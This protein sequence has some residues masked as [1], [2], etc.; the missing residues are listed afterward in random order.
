[1]HILIA[2]DDGYLAPGLL[3]LVNALRPLGKIT[4]IAPEQNHSGASNSLTLSRPLTVNRMAGG[5]RDNFLYVNGT[6][7]DCVH[8][9]LTGLLDSKPDL[10]VSGINQ[11][12]NMGE[13]V[14]YSGTVA[15]AIEGV[16]F[17]IPAIAFSQ[18]AKGWARLDDAAQIAR[19]IVMQQINSPVDGVLTAGEKPTLLN[20][21]I[22][23]LPYESLKS[24]RVTRL[25][26]RHH[27]QNVIMQNNP[28]G[29]PIYWIG[30][31]GDARD[32]TE[33]TDF[34]AINQGQVSITPLQ[35][36]LSHLK[37]REKMIQSQWQKN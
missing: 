27:S 37:T 23:N 31:P 36:D 2:N 3:A 6:P 28:R 1:M 29:E 34:H 10:V 9:A 8:I 32:A 12:E 17:G 11:G 4:V 16:M 19:D 13:D 5:D 35:L 24:W 20:V 30:P 15:A 21:N 22:P 18:V 33:G 26:N 7:T 14:L 25:G